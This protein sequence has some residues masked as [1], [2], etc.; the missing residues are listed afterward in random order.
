MMAAP[1]NHRSWSPLSLKLNA[2]TTQEM[3]QITKKT[4]IPKTA[5]LLFSLLIT[6][7]IRI[8]QTTVITIPRT[9]PKVPHNNDKKK[10][11]IK[12]TINASNMLN[13]L[14]NSAPLSPKG[15]E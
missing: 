7:A 3:M 9:V 10:G 4:I 12:A 6:P 2:M 5:F 13:A 11:A 8:K 15:D 1:P 14:A